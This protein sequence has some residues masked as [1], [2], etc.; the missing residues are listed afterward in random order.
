MYRLTRT[1]YS[2]ADL[3]LKKETKELLPAMPRHECVGQPEM[4]I[5]VSKGYY[6]QGWADLEQTGTCGV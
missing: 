5:R 1:M 4:P 2:I 6:R 3:F